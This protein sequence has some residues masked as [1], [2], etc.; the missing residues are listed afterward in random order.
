MNEPNL[1]KIEFPCVVLGDIHGQLFDAIN[2][3]SK[4][5][6]AKTKY[7]LLGDYVD[8]GRYSIETLT[9]LLAIK[10]NHPTNFGMLRGNHESL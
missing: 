2:V 6:P 1:I 7:M 4:K 10:L 9:L 5:N 3:L 8:R